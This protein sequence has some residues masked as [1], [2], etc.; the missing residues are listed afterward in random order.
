MG[1]ALMTP[2]VLF[3]I[4]AILVSLPPV[5]TFVK[6]KATAWLSEKTGWEVSID[7]ARLYFPLDLSLE[8]MSAVEKSDTLLRAQTLRL[9]VRILPLFSGKIAL[10]GIWLSKMKVDTKHYI[11]DTHIRGHVGL[12]NVEVP[13]EYSLRHS[14]LELGIVRLHD[15]DISVILSDTARQDT[16][17]SGGSKMKVLLHKAELKN[18]VVRLQM[19]GDSMRIMAGIGSGIVEGINVDL[20]Q[21][22]YSLKNI[23]IVRSS[24]DYDIPYEARDS[25]K[26]DFNH[27]SFSGLNLVADSAEYTGGKLRTRIAALSFK[28]QSGLKV[29]KVA[30]HVA[31]DGERITVPD[32]LL[33][34]PHSRLQARVDLAPDALTPGKSGRMDVGIEGYVGRQ[35]MIYLAGNTVRDNLDY[36]PDEPLGIKA[37]IVGNV[38]RAEI[39]QLE[40]TA[41][42]MAGISAKGVVKN[43]LAGNMDADMQ[44]SMNA[45]NMAYYRKLLPDGLRIPQHL[46]LGGRFKMQGDNLQANSTIRS[47]DGSLDLEGQVNVKTMEYDIIL[48]AIGFPLRAYLPDLPFSP[49]TATSH[50]KG[51]GFDFASPETT[52]DSKT[53]VQQ[54]SYGK[55]PLDNI[56]VD[57]TLVRQKLEGSLASGNSM[58][59]AHADFDADLSQH[60]VK[61]RLKGRIEDL[62]LEH[63]TQGEDSTHV[64]M[65]MKMRGYV[66]YDGSGMGLMGLLES[67]NIVTPSAGYPADSIGFRLGTSRDSTFAFVR[68]GDLLAR[69]FSP[70]CLDSITDGISCFTEHLRKQLDE[71]HIDQ[72]I[73]RQDLPT[74][75][76]HVKAGRF[77]PVSQMLRLQGYAFDKFNLDVKS[78]RENGVDGEMNVTNIRTGNIMLDKVSAMVSQDTANLKMACKIANTRKK[79]PNRFVATVQG[80]LL[81]DG[82]SMQAVLKDSKNIEGL[83]LGLRGELN[84]D[85]SISMHLFPETSTI[86]YRKFIVNKDNYITLA[87]DMSVLANVDLLADDQTGLKINA[88]QQDSAND[89]TVSLS[90]VNIDE[91]CQVVP[92]APSMGGFLTGDFHIIRQDSSLSA[93]GALEMENF[94][95]EAYNMGNFGAELVFLPKDEGE[96]YLNAIILGDGR[97]VANFDG[98]YFSRNDG[99]L[100]AVINLER[101]PCKLLGGFLPS[102]GTLA[103]DG[104]LGGSVM[105]TGPT[106][107]LRFNG[108]ILPESLLVYSPL[109]GVNLRMEDKPLAIR[110]SCIYM[111]TLTAYSAKS[112][113]PL[114]VNGNVN[115]RD[116][117]KITLDIAVKAKDFQIVNAERTKTSLLFGQVYSD[118][119]ATVKGSTNFM[120]IRG[121]LHILGKTNMT[122]IMKDSPLTVDDWLSGLVEFVDFT[123]TAEVKTEKA[124]NSKMLM[125]MNVKIDETSKIRCELSS[126]G[127]S[128]F[129]CRGGGNLVMKMLPS[130]G[131]NLLGTFHL[132]TGEMKYELPFIPLKTFKLTGENS[133]TFTGKPLNPALN[134][135]AMET[136]R[137]SVNDGATATRMVTFNVG[138]AVSQTLENMG[139][140]FLIEAPYD[141]NVQ[142]DLA[143]M[144]DDDKNKVAITM[145]ATGMYYSA[146]NKSSFKAN[147]ALNA[148]LQSEIQNLAGNALKTIDLTVGMEGSTSAGGNAQTDYSFRFSK[149]LW[150]DR[151]TFVIG[152]KVSAGAEDASRNQSFIDNISLEY[153]LDRNSTR[154]LRLFYDNDTQDPLEGNLSTAGAG[155]V[156]R[157]KT[158][159]LGELFL[160]P[161]KKT[162]HDTTH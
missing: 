68:S 22:S 40:V 2:V 148:F 65:K 20:G 72:M 128:Y 127:S 143:S 8:K 19:P 91:L 135:K 36:Y 124:E 71:T 152:G 112:A 48:K 94:R 121:N 160:K 162:A 85:R 14:L 30:G 129:D 1:I 53:F 41:G 113:E 131:M 3:F 50:L 78:V 56:H 49:L 93:S 31:Y 62:A 118:I 146:S 99:E 64:M 144:S 27:L 54:L 157:S 52:L 119:D 46:M 136:T 18:T 35:D 123:D 140:R 139:L 37:H 105:I 15:S 102:D 122:Y 98:T 66:R 9:G 58:L 161:R 101:F 95:F 117:D 5:Q 83:N 25:L 80:E 13:A 55:M 111:D 149:H 92:Y 103:L 114:T 67:V 84:A 60:D 87:P 115:F 153:R 21:D 88:T 158:N 6:N 74:L 75:E 134:I 130:G 77:N 73:L 106:S 34:T 142:N 138:V 63:L 33:M 126:D 70:T 39:R 23:R 104:A 76:A 96:F 107:S 51:K 82:F 159:S 147:N 29:D 11:S 17:Q 81:S 43:L 7:K 42:N 57:A 44:L 12:L 47:G 110:E 24:V 38:D 151:V 132:R 97:E 26:V 59:T 4:L 89:I 32:F 28:E 61:A 108:E 100:D 116:L 79:N 141:L 125:S 10:D 155:F 133:I 86:A 137:A 16:T 120:F 156:L 45:A 90:K 154:N 145:L 69:L 150:N 109:Y